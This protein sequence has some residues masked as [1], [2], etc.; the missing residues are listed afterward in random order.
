MIITAKFSS[1]CPHC[2]SRIN[3]GEKVE[4]SKGSK[5]A[6]VACTAK[7][8]GVAS[9][10]RSSYGRSS[11]GR[12]SSGQYGDDCYCRH[13]SSGSESLCVRDWGVA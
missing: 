10:S 7:A 2:N 11:Y 13:C 5:A 1:F 9:S 6:H 3:V 8:P 4:W 12:R